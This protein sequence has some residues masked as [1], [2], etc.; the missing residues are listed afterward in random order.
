MLHCRACGHGIDAATAGVRHDGP[1]NIPITGD[2]SVCFRCGEVS[3]YVIGPL[4]VALRE[5]TGAELTEFAAHPA[6]T[7]SV[8]EIH[9]FWANRNNS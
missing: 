2:Y 6:N 1:R 9:Q 8:R 7:E 5:P 4:G 3:V